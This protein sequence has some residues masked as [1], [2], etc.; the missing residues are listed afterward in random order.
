MPRLFI[1]RHGNTFDKGDVI[2]RVGGR[3]D[4]PLSKSGLAQAANIADVIAASDPNF[5]L[6]LSSPLART[7]ETVRIVRDRTAPKIDIETLDTMREI[8]YGP[9]ENQP[10]EAVI[11][12]IGA[13]ALA[14]WDA[15]AVPP[16]GWLVDPPALIDTWR[17][18]FRRCAAIEGDTLVVT[19]N[20]VARFALDAAN[21]MPKDAPR[22]LKTAAFGIVL[23]SGADNAA[24]VDW[25]VRS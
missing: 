13:D 20:G 17:Q 9:D 2:T 1:L 7:M 25:N 18:L 21:S 3:T 4:L 12:R 10:E 8:D 14:Q 15:A 22:K 11:A 6:I 23:L 5:A 16:P 24:I 19:S